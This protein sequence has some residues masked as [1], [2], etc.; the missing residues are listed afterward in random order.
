M[1]RTRH[2]HHIPKTELDEEP[3]EAVSICGGV[4]NCGQCIE[5][6]AKAPK[7]GGVVVPLIDRTGEVHKQVGWI[8]VDAEGNAIGEMTISDPEFT[9]KLFPTG[10]YSFGFEKD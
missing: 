5:D 3:Y 4:Y 7:H 2:G 10:M 8:E 9:K 1:A 6:A